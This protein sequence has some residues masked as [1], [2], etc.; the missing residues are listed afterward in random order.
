L[1]PICY[2]KVKGKEEILSK[3]ESKL[4]IKR[5]LAIGVSNITYMRNLFPEEAYSDRNFE[6]KLIIMNIFFV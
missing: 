3:V 5:M 4:F 6:G 1:H 2:F